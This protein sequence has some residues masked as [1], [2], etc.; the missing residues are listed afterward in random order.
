[1]C[2]LVKHLGVVNK[3]R[4]MVFKLC[5]KC[6]LF[7]QGLWHDM[8]KYS[9]SELK[10]SVKYFTDG[11][12]SPLGTAREQQGYS[13]AWLRHKGRN[14]HHIEYWYD[15]HN[16]ENM[17]IPYKYVVESLCDKIAATK[18]YR[19]AEYKAQDVLDYWNKEKQRFHLNP[20]IEK[21][22]DDVLLDLVNLGEK[23]VLNKKY[24]KAKYKEIVG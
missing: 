23:T 17:V 21:F 10:E 16:K 3:H 12:K 24:L 8:S 18:C 22:F 1:M 6:G 14:K 20:K 4:F 7:W 5:C 9:L 11:K 2:K 13:L 15:E 19:K